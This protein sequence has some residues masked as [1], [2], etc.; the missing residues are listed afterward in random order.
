MM[1]LHGF[2]SNHYQEHTLFYKHLKKYI[3]RHFYTVPIYNSVSQSRL[4]QRSANI[5]RNVENFSDTP[6]QRC[7][8][9][10]YLKAN[11]VLNFV[12]SI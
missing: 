10:A 5:I 8:R 2:T 9:A 4:A 6:L 3:A 12:H 11:G 7:V 1:N